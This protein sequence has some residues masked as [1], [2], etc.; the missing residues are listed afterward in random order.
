MLCSLLSKDASIFLVNSATVTL[1]APSVPTVFPNEL[2]IVLI[3]SSSFSAVE[4]P[5]ES[6]TFFSE[7]TLVNL[8]F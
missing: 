7:I 8:L 6:E 5:V 2:L 4:L 1:K 3:S